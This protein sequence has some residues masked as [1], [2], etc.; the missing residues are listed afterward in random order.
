MEKDT[1]IDQLH[2]VY[3]I[4]LLI[5]LMITSVVI[6]TA[7]CYQVWISTKHST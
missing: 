7:F 2:I 3:L 5:G 6:A 4:K 1:K